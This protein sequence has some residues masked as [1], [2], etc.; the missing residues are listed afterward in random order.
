[1]GKNS[2]AADIDEAIEGNVEEIEIDQEAILNSLVKQNGFKFYTSE[3][4][5]N[6]HP[7]AIRPKRFRIVDFVDEIVKTF[8][9]DVKQ[10]S[11]IASILYFPMLIFSGTTLPLEV[12]PT[13]MQKVVS[14][15]PL[16]Q[17]LTMMK[18]AF[19]GIGMGN[20]LVPVCVMLGLTALC[21]A[22]AVRFFR[23]E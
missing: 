22:L 23:W 17:S 18:N 5:Y 14:F 6:F 11:V 19:L 16:T 2:F 3:V 20:I 21:T 4:F 8:D 1:M 15:F 9:I 7:D 13:A 10:A 12:M